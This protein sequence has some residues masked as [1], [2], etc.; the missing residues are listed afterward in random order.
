MN[1]QLKILLL[2]SKKLLKKIP[3][4]REY[5]KQIYWENC[6]RFFCVPLRKSPNYFSMK[7]KTYKQVD[8]SAMG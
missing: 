4:W 6:R 8:G 2:L 1:I 5:W 7:L 3:I